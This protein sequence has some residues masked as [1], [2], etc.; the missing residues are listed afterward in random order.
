MTDLPIIKA[1]TMG[2]VIGDKATMSFHVS[3]DID[4]KTFFTKKL[5]TD[6]LGVIRGITWIYIP[7]GSTGE[8]R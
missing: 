5:N 6:E 4:S 2:I 3:E 7:E 8:F 1:G